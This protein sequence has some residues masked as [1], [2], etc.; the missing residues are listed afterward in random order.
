MSNMRLGLREAIARCGGAP[1]DNPMEKA[2][3][4]ARVRRAIARRRPDLEPGALDQAAAAALDLT[5]AEFRRLLDLRA[6][7]A[8]VRDQ[9]ADGAISMS[10]GLALR[11]IPEVR[12]QRALAREAAD[13]HLAPAVIGAAAEMLAAD[14]SL[15]VQVA[16]R[17]AQRGLGEPDRKSVSSRRL[18]A[19]G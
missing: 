10:Q 14:A 8:E 19:A 2:E 9:I 4:G 3:A 18:S 7:G 15:R 6:L 17:R 13:Q 5:P 16:I 1:A 12:R 11:P